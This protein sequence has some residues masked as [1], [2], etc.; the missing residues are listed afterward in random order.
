MYN[1][2]PSYIGLRQSSLHGLGLFA[3]EPIIADTDL[4][5]SHIEVNGVLVRTPLGGFYNHSETP[6]I[7]RIQVSPIQWNLFTLR[8]IEIDEELV[9]RYTLYTP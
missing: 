4:G 7:Q 2:L 1:P 3:K 8:N 9:A 5:M 6:N